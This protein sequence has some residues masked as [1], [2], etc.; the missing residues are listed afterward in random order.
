MAYKVG[1]RLASIGNEADAALAQDRVVITRDSILQWKLEGRCFYAQQGNAGTKLDWA[2]TAYD[3]DQPMFA[4]IV[5]QGCL[6]IPVAMDVVLEDTSGATEGHVIWSTTTNDIGAGTSTALTP[7]N[8]RRDAKYAPMCRANSKYSGDATAA[9]GL[10]EVRRWY[11]PFAAALVTDG[12]D[13]HN[14]YTWGINDPSMPILLGPAT[15]QLHV[16]ATGDG[17]HGYGQYTWIELDADSLGL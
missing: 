3:E 15:L 14:R 16:Y 13:L 12:T 11:I 1:R 9:T 2:D 8:Y 4:L 6:C 7:V 10:I 17:Y 5:P